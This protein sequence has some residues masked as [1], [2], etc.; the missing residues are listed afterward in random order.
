MNLGAL[1]VIAIVAA[2]ALWL[3]WIRRHDAAAVAKS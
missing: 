3:A 1:P 2:A